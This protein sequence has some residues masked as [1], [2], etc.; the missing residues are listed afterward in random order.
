[1]TKQLLEDIIC[2]AVNTSCE[3]FYFN[4]YMEVKMSFNSTVTPIKRGR[5]DAILDWLQMLSGV[6]LI[7]FVFMHMSLVSSVIFSPDIMDTIA[8]K[9]EENYMAQIGGPILFLLFLFHFYLAA[10]KIPFRLDGQKTIWK[11]AKML[12]HRDTWLWVVQVVSA[13]LILVMG[14]IH[15]WAVLSDLPITAARS[16]ERIQSGPWIFFYLVLAP[17]VIM[18]VVAGL[19]RIAV[20]WGFIKDYQRGRLNKFA[21]GLAI[22]FLCIGLATL[23]RFMTLAA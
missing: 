17:L 16:A 12:K 7:I 23:A 15:M 4:Y 11:H 3:V 19:Y 5:S 1:L 21:T 8:H 13:M 2:G 22:L 9:Y 18:H 14:S 10:R 6:A 20:K